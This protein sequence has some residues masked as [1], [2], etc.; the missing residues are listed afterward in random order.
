[1]VRTLGYGRDL[2][3]PVVLKPAGITLWL[4]LLLLLL[5]LVPLL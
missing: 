5:L 4:V 2:R 3:E 1:M